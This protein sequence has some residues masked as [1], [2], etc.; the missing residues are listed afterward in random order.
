MVLVPF[1]AG[2]QGHSSI[3]LILRIANGDK[4]RITSQIISPSSQHHPTL[5]ILP[6]WYIFND[7]FI[8]DQSSQL[9]SSY[10]Q[11]SISKQPQA[12]KHLPENRQRGCTHT[13]GQTSELG[14]IRMIDRHRPDL[15]EDQDDL[16]S[17]ILASDQ[18][19]PRLPC[20]SSVLVRKGARDNQ[21]YFSQNKLDQ[22]VGQDGT[23]RFRQQS[24][25][26][27]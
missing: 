17:V 21:E 10:D 19:H 23:Y 22:V 3:I 16:H 9:A 8:K 25:M 1:L 26:R 14:Q 12:K 2:L 6:S 24:R 18:L 15:L 27:R 11:Q 13:F 5:M 4:I 20:S 7:F